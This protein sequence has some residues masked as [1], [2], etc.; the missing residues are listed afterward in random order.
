MVDRKVVSDLRQ[1]GKIRREDDIV[2]VDTRLLWDDLAF[3]IVGDFFG[4]QGALVTN[5]QVEDGKEWLAVGPVQVMR[6]SAALIP[7]VFVISLAVVVS[8]AV[9]RAVVALLLQVTHVGPER[10]RDRMAA[11]HVLGAKSHGIGAM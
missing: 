4:K 2:R 10:F 11:A 3:A 6:F 9:V 7:D 1:V 5:S 8:L